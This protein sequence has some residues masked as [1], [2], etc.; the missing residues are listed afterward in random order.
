MLGRVPAVRH[1]LHAVRWADANELHRRVRA[2]R[3]AAL[4]GRVSRRVPEWI[5]VWGLETFGE[6]AAE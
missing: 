2:V 3:A 5:S 4:P 6:R 1:E